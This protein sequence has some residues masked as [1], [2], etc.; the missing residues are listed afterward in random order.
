M[1][2]AIEFTPDA[3]EHFRGFPKRNQQTILESVYQHLV[4]EPLVESKKRKP[5]QDSHLA[6][7]EL[8]IGDIRVFYDV[9]PDDRLVLVVAIGEKTH[10]ILRIAGEVV[11]R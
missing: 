2:F 6:E 9:K 1:S 8:R 4:H 10:N 11:Q 3:S 7:W 5:L